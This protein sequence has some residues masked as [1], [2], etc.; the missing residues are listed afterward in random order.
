MTTLDYTQVYETEYRA[1]RPYA[2]LLARLVLAA[3]FL[4]R[5]RFAAALWRDRRR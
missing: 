2:R 1:R 5:P 3:L 4:L